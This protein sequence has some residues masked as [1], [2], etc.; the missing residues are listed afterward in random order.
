MSIQNAK[1][2]LNRTGSFSLQEKRHLKGV[3]DTVYADAGITGAAM[4]TG[5]GSG[6]TSGTGTV[7][8]SRVTKSNGI[9]T[10]Q[11]YIDLTGLNSGGTAG[12]IIGANAA[13]NSH[14]G[15]ITTAENGLIFDTRLICLEVP[16]GG[17]TDITVYGAVESTGAE[18]AAITTL[19]EI[20]LANQDLT[21][22]GASDSGSGPRPNDYIYLVGGGT[23]N[24]TYTAGKIKIVFRGVDTSTLEA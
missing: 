15:R 4:A 16:V 22:I 17:D 13:A 19:D 18:D 21:S 9:I 2:I 1:R 11:I 7:V 6:I 12:D 14:F 3:L 5:P 10:T 24:D 20:A 23:S 8:N